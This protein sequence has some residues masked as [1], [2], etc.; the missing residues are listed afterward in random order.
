M[1]WPKIRVKEVQHL[2]ES[3]NVFRFSQPLILSTSHLTSA[4]DPEKCSVVCEAWM[5]GSQES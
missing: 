1:A 3:T 4:E 5:S 2:L